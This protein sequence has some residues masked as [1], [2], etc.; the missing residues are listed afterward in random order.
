LIHFYKR[1][2]SELNQIDCCSEWGR[3]MWASGLRW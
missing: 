2:I 3:W 1:P